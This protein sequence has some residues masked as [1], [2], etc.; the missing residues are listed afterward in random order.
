MEHLNS[1]RIFNLI[2]WWG[3]STFRF[4]LCYRNMKPVTVTLAFTFPVC[5]CSESKD[6]SAE[7]PLSFADKDFSNAKSTDSVD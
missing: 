1:A 6:V 7:Q 5:C 2:W 3:G 4:T